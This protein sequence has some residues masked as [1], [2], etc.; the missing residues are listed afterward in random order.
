VKRPDK[1]NPLSPPK[2][3]VSQSPDNDNVSLNG[4]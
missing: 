4:S 1:L 3:D 2:R